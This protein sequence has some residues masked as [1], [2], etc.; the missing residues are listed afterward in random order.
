LLALQCK[1]AYSLKHCR[2]T[3]D[4]VF[5]FVFLFL[6]LFFQKKISVP[7]LQLEVS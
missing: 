6:F 4:F 5:L 1:K 7:R 3:S 2:D